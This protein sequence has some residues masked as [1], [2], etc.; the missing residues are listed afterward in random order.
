MKKIFYIVLLLLSIFVLSSCEEEEIEVEKE[1]VFKTISKDEYYNK[2][3]A[4]VLGQM[5]GFLS[6]YEF[7]WDGP[8]PRLGMPEEWFEFLNGPCSGNYTHFHPGA[9]SLEQNHNRYDR[10]RLNEATGRYEVYGDDDFHIDFFNQ[11][12]LKEYGFSSYAIKTAWDT[13]KVSDWGGGEQAMRL[14][15]SYGLLSPFTGTMEAGN[16]YSW[17][18]EAYIENETLGMDAPGMMYQTI[19]LIDTF[20]ANVGYD[21]P[22]I[23]AKFYSSMYSIAYF[24]N[25]VRV[26]MDYAK[27]TMP[28]GSYPRYV[29]EESLKIYERYPNDYQSAAYEAALLL[30]PISGIDNIQTDPSVNGAFAI[31]SLLYG[32][33]DYLD[34]CKYASLLG[35][36]ADCTASIVTGLLGIIHGHKQD[37]EEYQLLNEKMYYDGEGLYVND[38]ITGYQTFISK[39][40]PEKQKFTDIAKLYQENFE[41]ILLVNGGTITDTEYIIPT[42]YMN[43]KD[44]SLLFDNYDAEKRDLTGYE[45]NSVKAEV[46]EESS[47]VNVH[48]GYASIKAT[49]ESDDS[50]GQIYHTFN[51]LKKGKYYRVS[52]YVQTNSQMKLFASTKK[53]NDYQ[54]ITFANSDKFINKTFIFKATDKTMRVGFEFGKNAKSDSFIIFDD[55]YIEEVENEVISI[56]NVS[57]RMN[58]YTKIYNGVFNLPQENKEYVLR[59]QYRNANKKII[60]SNLTLNGQEYG[61]VVLSR[62]SSN[63]NDGYDYVEIPIISSSV[64]NEFSL[65]FGSNSVYI[66]SI[67]VVEKEDYTFR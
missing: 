13:H 4:G 29:Y 47:C 44:D 55:F 57:T 3:L 31:L 16:I 62:T 45:T 25:D 12:I 61:S 23:W 59:I 27:E 38:K 11:L 28:K 18:T 26:I 50:S 32:Q 9:G 41:N 66:G 5:A 40:Y 20:A 39:D 56:H 54:Y 37:N 6:G 34:T 64:A 15:N 33:N 2:T 49:N 43:Y 53:G 60:Y 17:C 10:L 14:I 48:K 22:I 8:D 58:R 35:Y 52:I 21:E 67:E 19:D 51:K 65:S 46:I 7:V 36:D 24:E 1:P 30:R 63:G 42:D